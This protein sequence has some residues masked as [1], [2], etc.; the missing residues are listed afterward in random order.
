MAKS[1][2]VRITALYERLSCADDLQG[3]SNSISN[4]KNISRIT[5]L[6]MDSDMLDTS[7]MMDIAEQTS[8]VRASMTCWLK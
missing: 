7:Q 3:E 6:Q 1:D 2:S 4:Q 8:I 5:Q